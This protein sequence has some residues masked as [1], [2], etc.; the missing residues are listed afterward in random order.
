MAYA[1]ALTKGG[2]MASVAQTE[3]ETRRRGRDRIVIRTLIWI[4]VAN[5]VVAGLKL[6]FGYL[7]GS[8]SMLADGLHSV[9]DSGSNVVGLA[10][11]HIA[12]KGPDEEHPYGHRKFE[13]L[14]GALDE[15]RALISKLHGR[16]SR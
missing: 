16:A 8:V 7:A 3:R 14:A 10:A 2:E 13:A 6:F 4:L 5:L 12:R 15:I 11:I 1:G 9:L